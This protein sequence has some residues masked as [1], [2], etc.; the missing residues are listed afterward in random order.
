MKLVIL[1]SPYAGKGTSHTDIAENVK[2]AILCMQDSLRRG[3][4]PLATHLLYAHSG[5]SDDTNL[6]D[7][8]NCMDA[9]L[10]W[11]KKAAE[12]T[13]VYTD[14]GISEGMEYGIERAKK[15]GRPVKYRTILGSPTQGED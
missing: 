11:G 7:R 15:E 10:E 1:E 6:V 4:A 2:Y 12:E 5:V 8:K 3:E 9:G 13:V 14:R